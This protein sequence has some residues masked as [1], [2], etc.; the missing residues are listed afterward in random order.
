MFREM[1]RKHQLLD[2]QESADILRDGTAGVLALLGDEDYPYAVPISYVYENSRIYFHGAKTGHKIDA[3]KKHGKASFCVIAQDRVVPEAYTTYFKSVIVF[4]RIRVLEDEGE[5]REAAQKLAVKY[6]PQDSEAHRN[7][8]IAR[9]WGALCILEL[10]IEH[11]TGK[12]AKE[13]AKSRRAK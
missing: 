6:H 2:S 9:E 12:E 4:G 10:S 11:M 13:L 1:R 7:Q 5:I 3:V 8:E